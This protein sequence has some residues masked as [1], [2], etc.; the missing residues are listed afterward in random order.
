MLDI[1]KLHPVAGKDLELSFGA[2]R[3]PSK[4]YRFKLI[5]KVDDGRGFGARCGCRGRWWLRRGSRPPEIQGHYLAVSVTSVPY[6]L[7]SRPRA[8]ASWVQGLQMRLEG[9]KL[10]PPFGAA[11]LPYTLNS[12]P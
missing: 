6:S 3:L 9:R 2:A 5:E 8:L 7:D 12:E 10:E 1:V 11:R 4:I